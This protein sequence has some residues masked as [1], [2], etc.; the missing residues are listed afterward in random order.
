MPNL[1]SKNKK[2]I[3]KD[4]QENTTSES[5][6][7]LLQDRI[8]WLLLGL[9]GGIVATIIV[10]N[11]EAILS[12]DLRLA[13]FIPIIVYLS[14]AV[15]TQSETIFIRSLGN[16]KI[17]FLNYVLKESLVGL[18]LGFLFGLFL[19]IFAAIWLGS[20]A[21]AFTVG[22]AAMINLTIAPILAVIIPTLIRKQHKDP[23]LGAGPVATIIQDMLS[24]LVFFFIA[25]VI[26]LS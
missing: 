12:A 13:F 11:Y 25:S 5:V 15:G 16:K 17:N 9:G 18:A 19:G 1:T 8:P 10:S 3:S 23:A 14:D 2:K 4:F 6:E 24:L 7:H 20:I 22:I 21:I 26:I